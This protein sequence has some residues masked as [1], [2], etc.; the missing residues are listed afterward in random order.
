MATAARDK[1]KSEQLI[2]YT[3]N[4]GGKLGLD[5]D[6]HVIR[7]VKLLG[8]ES[9]NGRSYSPAAMKQAIPLY[10]GAK[11][12]V[13]HPKGNPGSPRD[14]QDRLGSIKGV[15]YVEGHGLTGD[16]HYNPKHPVAPALEHDAEFSPENVGLSHNVEARTTRRNGRVVV[17]S[18]ERV[19]SVDLV[20]DPATTNG[21]YEHENPNPES[22]D[23]GIAELTVEQILAQR[24]DVK[25]LL[26][27][28]IIAEHNQSEEV[29]TKDAQIKSLKEE[30]DQ[31][32]LK[33]KVSAHKTSVD[34][35][36]T[37]SGLEGLKLNGFPVVTDL[38]RET[39]YEADDAKLAKLIEER[40]GLC[41]GVAQK[42]AAQKTKSTDQNVTEGVEFSDVSDS[43]TFAAALRR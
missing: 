40:V 10:E 25:E 29:R 36:I 7:G 17:E 35:K 24:P 4:A 19:K 42:Q 9:K 21:L 3:S 12:N 13:N 41:K 23:M 6:Q 32:K 38:F 39:C 33:D 8:L 5:K 43:K 22:E 31:L 1:S 28:K 20:A 27:P 18:I 15:R 34:K 30:L 11:V 26:A 16:L 37:E 2:E 14:Y